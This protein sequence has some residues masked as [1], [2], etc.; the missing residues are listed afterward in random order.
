MKLERVT[1]GGGEDLRRK[2]YLQK[3]GLGNTYVV[4]ITSTIVNITHLH[5][6]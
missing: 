4:Y 5:N 2:L 6:P 3:D 1:R